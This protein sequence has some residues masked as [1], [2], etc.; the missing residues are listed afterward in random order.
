MKAKKEAQ[1]ERRKARVRKKVFGTPAT[2]RLTVFRSAKHMYAQIIDDMKNTTLV[3]ASTLKKADSKGSGNVK[4]AKDVGGDIAEKAK[5]AKITKVVF[6]RNGYK[7]HG[8]VKALAEAAREKG[9]K[10]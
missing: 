1:R 9:L 6:D 5:A 3:A 2:P 10:F 7:Y 8:R 4:G